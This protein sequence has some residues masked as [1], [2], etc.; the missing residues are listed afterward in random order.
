M[1]MGE[2][3]PN[4]GLIAR[5]ILDAQGNTLALIRNAGPGNIINS[6]T[7]DTLTQAEEL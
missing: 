6:A 5:K 3:D 2:A 1:G 7:C 4:D